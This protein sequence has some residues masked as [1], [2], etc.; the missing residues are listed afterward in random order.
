MKIL[1]FGDSVTEM[2]RDYSGVG[3]KRFGV[4][5]PLL[6]AAELYKKD[7]AKYE[8][9]NKGIGGNRVVDLYARIKADVWNHAPDVVSI[10]IGVNDLWHEIDVFRNG[11]D[12]VR[13]EK[14]YRMIIDDTLERFPKMKFIL[15][16]PCF[17]HGV[18][19][20]EKFEKFKAIYDYAAVAKKLAKEYGFPFVALQQKLNEAAEKHGAER[21]LID[22]VHPDV[23]GAKLIADEWLKVFNANF[24]E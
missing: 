6:V 15:C 10:M 9:I 7:V 23:A 12:I 16:E 5:Y 17:L 19:T 11:V 24:L 8:V 1:F 21:Y 20:D 22:G 4:G 2:G 3:F 18:S 13:F 14:V